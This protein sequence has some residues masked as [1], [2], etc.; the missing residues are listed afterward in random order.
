MILFYIYYFFWGD[1]RTRTQKSL[2]FGGDRASGNLF[3][4]GRWRSCWIQTQ[5]VRGARG[6]GRS[7]RLLR[8][9]PAGR[10]PSQ[11][12]KGLSERRRLGAGGRGPGRAGALP[13]TRSRLRAAAALPPASP[14][15]RASQTRRR[16]ARPPGRG[17]CRAPPP[18]RPSARCRGRG[19]GGHSLGRLASLGPGKTRGPPRALAQVRGRQPARPRRS[20]RCGRGRRARVGDPGE[21]SAPR[22]RAGTGWRA[23]RGPAR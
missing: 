23:R 11:P 13:S 2:V 20:Y 19:R 9:Q 22:A 17:E 14:P 16:P 18:R 21:G 1:G 7:P 8:V 3:L 15:R 12:W 4:A 5:A 6:P 10:G